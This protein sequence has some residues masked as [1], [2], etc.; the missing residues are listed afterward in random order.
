MGR[1]RRS[2]IALAAVLLTQPS[3]L[4]EH[5]DPA[6]ELLTWARTRYEQAGLSVPEVSVDVHD[7]RTGCRGHVAVFIAT[8]PLPEIHLCFDDDAP[9]LL[10]QRVALHELAHAWVH[11]HV[12]DEDIRTF[13]EIR[14]LEHWHDPAPWYQQ[15]TEHAAEIMAWGLLETDLDVLTIAPD[16]R[17]SLRAAFR[18]LTGV[19]PICSR[20]DPQVWLPPVRRDGHR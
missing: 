16:D 7:D 20:P 14:D 19:D 9:P 17:A 13:L 3:G 1:V 2:A 15:G 8:E 12:S 18:F 4:G 6:A 11:Q 5:V 10:R